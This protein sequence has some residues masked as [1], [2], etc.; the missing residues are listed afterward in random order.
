MTDAMKNRIAERSPSFKARMAGLFELLEAVTAAV[1]EVI[2]LGN[3]IV[4]GN[5][6]ATA[7]NVLGH[8]T[9]FWFGF[10]LSVVGVV[11]HIVVALLFYELFMP[12]SRSIS[13][14]AAFI[15]LVASAVQA[16]MCLFYAAPL[17]VWNGANSPAV[18]GAA[19]RGELGYLLLRLNGQAFKLHLAFFGFWCILIGYLIF[20]SAFMPRILGVLLAIA[21]IG[22]TMYVVPPV[23][24]HL[25]AYINAA[26][27]LGEIP[28]MFWLI[29]MG[30]NAE[31]WKQ[32]AAAAP[33]VFA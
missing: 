1:G 10:A 11:C 13:R 8:E 9:R 23:A 2:I 7:A 19:E 4:P 24:A 14:L 29:V 22:W 16:M 32:R 21:G 6:S 28:L 20:K 25:Y 26:S 27:A 15:L 31:R 30:V 18:F 12:A 3:L 17:L 33:R 5:A